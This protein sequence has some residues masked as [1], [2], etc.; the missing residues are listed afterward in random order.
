MP[1]EVDLTRYTPS[2]A[3][4]DGQIQPVLVPERRWYDALLSG[5]G[6]EPIERWNSKVFQDLNSS[7]A[8]SDCWAWT[9]SRSEDGYGT[10]S[11]GGQTARAHHVLWA[12]E[13]GS[14]PA[15]VFGPKGWEKVHLG[16]LCHDR[17]ETCAGGPS[18]L[19]R[20]CVNPEHLALQSAG[21]NA[22]AGHG[23]DHLRN[24]THC[25]SGH[26]YAVD[27]F[28]YT[29]PAGKTRRYCRPCKSGQRAAQFVG[30]RKALEVAA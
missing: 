24:R 10:F 28:T 8:S 25:P 6:D 22:R 27:G 3:E 12:L 4:V 20:R 23:S 13:H 14:P 16:H 2:M 30:S 26:E 29:D 1:Q 18:C 19:H 9:A 17:D 5:Q 15:Y 11:L 7:T 21:E